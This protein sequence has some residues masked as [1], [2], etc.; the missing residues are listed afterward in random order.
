MLLNSI[1]IYIDSNLGVSSIPRYL[2]LR[3]Q[4]CPPMGRTCCFHQAWKQVQRD[5]RRRRRGTEGPRSTPR[6]SYYGKAK[7]PSFPPFLPGSTGQWSQ[8]TFHLLLYQPTGYPFGKHN[9]G[10]IKHTWPYSLLLQSMATPSLA[11]ARLD[12][13]DRGTAPCFQQGF[14]ACLAC[15]VASFRAH[16]LCSLRLS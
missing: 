15:W 13:M 7:G 5:T 1:C 4:L 8:V 2:V 12:R 6:L 10:R 9:K 11:G 14:S 16:C 3:L